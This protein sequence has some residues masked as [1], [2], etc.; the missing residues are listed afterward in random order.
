MKILFCGM[1]S[2][3]Q[4]HAEIIY[5]KYPKHQIYTYKS[6][7]NNNEK[8][9]SFKYT[10]IV[11]EEELLTLKP[12]VAFITN[13][14]SLHIET[15]LR[16][17]PL[18]CD[19]FIEKPLSNNMDKVIELIGHAKDNAII[20]LMGCNMRF[21]PLL[22]KLKD[23]VTSN[24][25]GRPIN[26]SINC[27]SYLP[28]WRPNQDYTKSYSGNKDLGGGVVFDLIHELDYTKWIFGKFLYVKAFSGKKSKLKINSDDYSNI[29]VETKN[30][31]S[32][33][34]HLDYY[35]INPKRLI[36]VIF[37]EVVVTADL[38]KN[39]II[40][41]NETNKELL[42]FDVDRNYTYEKQIE[43]FFDCIDKRLPTFNDIKEGS[44][45]LS[46]A[47]SILK[48]SENKGSALK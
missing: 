27:G 16:L 29:I 4:R 14:T 1:G 11:S 6:S 21:N 43:Y 28:K 24:N 23:I 2:I 3:G 33:I 18:K 41:E 9:V 45:T 34:I 5:R 10:N 36:E 35:R 44:E 7:L 8:Q 25:Y 40:I 46:Y 47:L 22:I 38:I 30:C 13:P 48:D 12:D 26:F 20:T 15:A 17:F 37:N 42:T 39:E 31:I 19:L 32:G